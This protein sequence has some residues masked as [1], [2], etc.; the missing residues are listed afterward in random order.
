MN[1]KFE[2]AI[3]KQKFDVLKNLADGCDEPLKIGAIEAIRQVSKEESF[4]CLTTALRNPPPHIRAAAAI[5]L[6]TLKNP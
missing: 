4:H 2:H 6:N 3:A 5:E 1:R